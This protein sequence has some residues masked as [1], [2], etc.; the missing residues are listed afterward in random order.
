M[1]ATCVRNSPMKDQTGVSLTW[2]AQRNAG[3]ED[4]EW[5]TASNSTNTFPNTIRYST[6]TMP[7]TTVRDPTTYS[8]GTTVCKQGRTTGYTCGPIQSTN[9]ALTY[10]GVSGTYVRVA[11]DTGGTMCDTGD[12]GGPIFQLNTAL[13]IM[14]SKST[15]FPGQCYFMPIQ[16]ISSLGLSVV[17]S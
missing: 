2:V 12:S 16:R 15:S 3:G 17:T 11:R 5:R 7:V 14:H 10:N 6:T 1:P 4:Y 13:G 9:T 8:V